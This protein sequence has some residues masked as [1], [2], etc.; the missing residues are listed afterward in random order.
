MSDSD[1]PATISA[2]EINQ[3]R[4]EHYNATIIERIDIH[5]ALARFR[6]R[7]D[8][9]FRPFKPGQYVALGIGNWE[10]RLPDTQPEHLDEKKLRKLVRRA[11]SISCPLIANKLI[12][13]KLVANKLVAN[14]KS[15]GS[16]QSRTGTAFGT[17]KPPGTDKA[18]D[19]GKYSDAEVIEV[20]Q[21]DYLEFYVALVRY[22]SDEKGKSPGLTPRLFGFEVGDRIEV[23]KKI[24][25]H[26]VAEDIAS[27]DTVL[28][29][30]T[31]TGEAP[32][33][34]MVTELLMRGHA[35]PIINVTSV[36]SSADLGY[37]DEHRELARRFANYRYLPITTRDPINL[38]PDHPDYVGKQYVQTLFT[39]G[40]LSE[41]A[42]TEL[43]PA[44]TH[45]FLCGN[46]AMIG[47]TPPGADPPKTPGMIQVLGDHGFTGA[48][49]HDGLGKIRFEKYW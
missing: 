24:V 43:T 41:L 45:A 19:T 30:S 2:E 44:T 11:Y 37:T 33:N 12:A 38:D 40:K 48:D 34:A 22:A 21:I 31:G 28:L 47:Y 36:R 20:N 9:G 16:D 1:V 7:P 10:P 14:K 26:Y 49:E 18:P 8:D 17:D 6:I 15:V 42:G 4:S 39:S 3:L 32:H 35:G 27:D 29:I 46:P 5:E 13:N 25:G 23:Q